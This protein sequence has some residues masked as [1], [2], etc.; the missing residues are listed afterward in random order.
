MNDLVVRE[1][2]WVHAVHHVKSKLAD[3]H[4]NCF[5]V[6]LNIVWENAAAGI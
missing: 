6:G 5:E 1:K 2:S 3:V 4:L